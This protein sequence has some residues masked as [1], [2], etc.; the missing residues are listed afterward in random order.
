LQIHSTMNQS[1]L[2]RLEDPVE[3]TGKYRRHNYVNTHKNKDKLRRTEQYN[4]L[5]SQLQRLKKL[6]VRYPDRCHAELYGHAELYLD[7]AKQEQEQEEE[8][9]IILHHPVNN[10]SLGKKC[11]ILH[12]KLNKFKKTNK[13]DKELNVYEE[14]LI[15]ASG[16]F[17]EKEYY[18]HLVEYTDRGWYKKF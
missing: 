16:V 8:S 9:E 14:E 2:K 10:A 17:W 5:K 7:E 4:V 15:N 11:G 3:S 18:L 12:G 6:K 1:I 13:I